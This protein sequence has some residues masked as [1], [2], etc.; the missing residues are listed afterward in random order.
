[1]ASISSTWREDG[2]GDSGHAGEMS[3]TVGYLDLPDMGRPA[4]VDWPGDTCDPTVTDASDVVRVDVEA[5]GAIAV[6]RGERCAAGSERFSEQH[7]YAAMEDADR[8]ASAR[9]DGCPRANE[10]VPYFQKFNAEMR[11]RRVDVKLG[12]R[13]DG[14]RLL[15]DGSHGAT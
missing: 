9:V 14:D 8:L 7:R 11:D 12:E 1:M 4:H 6:R 2:H 10:V 5:H 13:I 15:P 3:G